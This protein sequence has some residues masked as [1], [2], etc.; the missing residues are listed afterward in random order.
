MVRALTLVLLLLLLV[1]TYCRLVQL[2]P[3]DA[4]VRIKN[5]MAHALTPVLLMLVVNL[6]QAC[7]AV[8]ISRS[9]IG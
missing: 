9:S 2:S 1:V 4:D 6:L 3:A 8:A 7:A 5:A